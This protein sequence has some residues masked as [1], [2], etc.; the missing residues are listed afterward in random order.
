MLQLLYV[1]IYECIY[2]SMQR[3]EAYMEAKNWQLLLKENNQYVKIYLCMNLWMYICIN[4]MKWSIHGIKELTIITQKKHDYNDYTQGKKWQLIETD[5]IM[6]SI[7]L[8]LNWPLV[9]LIEH[10]PKSWRCFP[11]GILGF[12]FIYPTPDIL[13]KDNNGVNIIVYLY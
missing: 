13:A 12:T 9:A 4:A 7:S 11:D 2:V 10:E 8:L 5:K 6:Y 1:W 3:N